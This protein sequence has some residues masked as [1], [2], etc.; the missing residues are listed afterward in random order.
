[1]ACLSD[2]HARL[3]ATLQGGNINLAHLAAFGGKA[4]KNQWLRT[5]LRTAALFNSDPE[6]RNHAKMQDHQPLAEATSFSL[7]HEF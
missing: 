5:K 6:T 4:A 3:D 2:G 7:E 1:V